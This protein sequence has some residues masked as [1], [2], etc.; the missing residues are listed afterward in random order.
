MRIPTVK[1]T[2]VTEH[3]LVV[4]HTTFFI[5]ETAK[6]LAKTPS[7][8]NSI[9]K[10]SVN[11]AILDINL[12]PITSVKNSASQMITVQAIAVYSKT[13]SSAT[14][15]SAPNAPKATDNNITPESVFYRLT[16]VLKDAH[17]A[18]QTNAS[19]V[20]PD[21]LPNRGPFVS[22]APSCMV[23][24][25]KDNVYPF[26]GIVQHSPT[27]DLVFKDSVLSVKKGTL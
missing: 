6:L 16:I 12:T 19:P 18:L 14:K 8:Q 2:T 21:T 1:Q 17:C 24:I 26:S 5:A 27:A 3:V 23:E 22:I 11:N 9:N 25:L 10:M 4:D 7:A 15:S 13:V 20:K